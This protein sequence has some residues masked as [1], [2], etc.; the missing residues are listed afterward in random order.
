MRRAFTLIELL[1]V[2]AIIAI[3][4]GMLL[5]ALSKAKAKADA[6][7]CVSNI[8]QLQLAWQLYTDEHDG[9]LVPNAGGTI[10]NNWVDGQANTE[11]DDSNIRNGLL[12]RYNASAGI[13]KCPSFKQKN[14]SNVEYFRSYAMQWYVGKPGIGAPAKGRLEEITR[15]SDCFVFVDQQRMDNSHFGIHATNYNGNTSP[16]G[17]NGWYSF[18]NS[19][20]TAPNNGEMP[21]TRHGGP[22]SFSFAD[23]RAQAVKF[24]GDFV[25]R[26]IPG[27]CA[28]VDL[29]DLRMVQSWLPE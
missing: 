16:T 3:L 23:G 17:V 9:R 8:K 25:K 15:P 20:G 11:T 14:S 19:G 5:P 2:I 12:Y 21:A 26:G 1:V 13:Y 6:V 4:A 27:P 18:I 10:G 28:G 29:Q 24:N 22:T 7:K